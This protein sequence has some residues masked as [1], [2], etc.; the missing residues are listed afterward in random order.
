MQ[1]ERE[2]TLLLTQYKYYILTG[3]YVLVTGGALFRVSRQPY[4]ARLKAGQYET[5]LKGTTLAAVLAGIA[6]GGR[7]NKVRSADRT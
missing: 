3:L 6:I 4:N 2:N 7:L 1:S 5:V